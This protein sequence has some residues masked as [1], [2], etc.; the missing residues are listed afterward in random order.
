M[1]AHHTR[2]RGAT[3]LA[4]PNDLTDLIAAEAALPKV[5]ESGDQKAEGRSLTE[6]IEADKYLAR[7]AARSP[8]A[9]VR[10]VRVIPPGTVE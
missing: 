2:T 6:L 10:L 1:Y 8:K 4:D 7:K 9:G 3:P 5:S